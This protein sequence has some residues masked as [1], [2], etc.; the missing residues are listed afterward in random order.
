MNRNN[1][2]QRLTDGAAVPK[3]ITF[4]NTPSFVT[5]MFGNDIAW[6]STFWCACWTGIEIRP[7]CVGL[8][9]SPGIYSGRPVSRPLAM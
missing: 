4:G 1:T 2:Y 6:M 8:F 3:S 7:L 9:W 5:E